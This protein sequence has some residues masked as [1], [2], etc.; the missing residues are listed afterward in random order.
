M[1]YSVQAIFRSRFE[2]PKSDDLHLID[3]TIFL[4]DVP[5]GDLPDQKAQSV[6]K[7]YE[8]D[9]LNEDGEKVIWEL[10]SI[11]EIQDLCAGTLYDGVEVFSR[12]EWAAQDSASQEDLP[13]KEG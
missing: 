2:G 3:R 12:L 10:E 1:W 7:Q 8:H 5:D 6:A 13:A 4:I 9:Y 11:L